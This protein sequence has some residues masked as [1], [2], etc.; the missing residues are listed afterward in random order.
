MSQLPLTMDALVGVIKQSC[1][2]AT[3]SLRDQWIDECCTIISNKRE[4]IEK[5]MPRDSVGGLKELIS[6]ALVLL[7]STILALLLSTIITLCIIFTYI[8][9]LTEPREWMTSLIV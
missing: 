7:L 5:W 2:K 9:R 6:I 8:H 1:D 4:E 3:S